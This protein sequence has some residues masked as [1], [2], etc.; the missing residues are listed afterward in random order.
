M[1]EPVFCQN[2]G[3]LCKSVHVGDNGLHY[4]SRDCEITDRLIVKYEWAIILTIFMLFP[5]MIM[6]AQY[7]ADKYSPTT[8]EQWR[9]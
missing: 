3:R 1:I 7:M 8:Q 9:Q 2:C 6:T 4:C 5:A